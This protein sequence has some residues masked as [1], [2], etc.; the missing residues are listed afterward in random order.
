MVLENDI[1]LLNYFAM[2]N[3]L[4]YYD[5]NDTPKCSFPL[6]TILNEETFLEN[7]VEMFPLYYMHSDVYSRVNIV[8]INTFKHSKKIVNVH[9]VLIVAVKVEVKVIVVRK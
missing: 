3:P 7:P 5:R 1:V 2:F 9:G 6:S 8:I 4:D